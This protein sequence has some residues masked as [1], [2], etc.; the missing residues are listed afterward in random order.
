[1]AK[2]WRGLLEEESEHQWIAIAGFFVFIILGALAIQGTSS[3]P[4]VEY[5]SNGL[6]AVDGRV[7]DIVYGDSGAYTAMILGDEGGL[8]LHHDDAGIL[9][10][11]GSNYDDILGMTFMTEL[12]DGSI[13]VSPSNNTLEIIHV[14]AE[15]SQRTILPLN[16]N[17]ENFDV[18]DV[19]EQ[20]NGDSYRWLMVTDEE[21]STSLRG[22]GSVGSSLLPA[23]DAFGGATLTAAMVNSGNIAWNMVEALDDGTW[24]AI[25]STT[26]AFGADEDSPAAPMKHPV[27]GF[28][29]WSAGPTSPMLTSIEELDKGEIHSLVRLDN[30]T[31]L[32]AGT[33]SAVHIAKDRTTT[34]VDFSSVSATL[35]ENGAVW[36]FGSAGST[37]VV[38][39]VDGV[40]EKMPLAQPLL[41][42]IETSDVSNDVVYAYGTNAN[43]DAATYSIDTLAIGSIES[44]RGFLNFL[45]VTASTIVIGVMLWTASKRMRQNQ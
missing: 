45:F 16:S 39:M 8:M 34:T 38:R 13:V 24:I 43:G 9:N 40:A 42:T 4:G 11:I 1:M 7:L 17:Q 15:I 22:F 41:L 6:D 26:N 14:N 36:L 33:D 12:H 35:D 37:S 44:G 2:G 23:Q 18:L 19:A 30:G 25:G 3:L 32:A 29:S 5:R 10:D 28:I 21:N 27:I 31:L 20:R